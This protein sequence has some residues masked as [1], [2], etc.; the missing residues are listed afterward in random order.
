MERETAFYPIDCAFT[1]HT[2]GPNSLHDSSLVPQL[3]FSAPSCR[4]S[5]NRYTQ[6]P[7]YLHSLLVLAASWSH[8]TPNCQTMSCI[9]FMCFT[10][11]HSGRL[12]SPPEQHAFH[13][14]LTSTTRSYCP[15]SLC[16]NH[17]FLYMHQVLTCI[18]VP[19][20]ESHLTQIP[21]STHC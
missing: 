17:P 4:N 21:D 11:T 19:T 13:L 2:P 15:H 3:T 16:P 12:F 7:K 10:C 5:L 20:N 8:T 9:Q 1:F 6:P 14:H 18:P